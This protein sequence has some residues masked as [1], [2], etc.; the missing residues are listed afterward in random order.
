MC[1]ILFALEIDSQYPL[2]IAS[3]R[4]E[5]YER[6][7]QQAQFWEQNPHLL[8]GRDLKA[9]G[10]WLGVTRQRRLAMVTNF[11]GSVVASGERSRGALVQRFLV[12]EMM[13]EDYLTQIAQEADQYAGFNLVVAD[14]NEV[15]YY[16]NRSNQAPRRL[17]PGIYGLS[18]HL[19][20][21]PWPKVCQGKQ[22]LTQWLARSQKNPEDL[23]TLLA[24]P[25]TA[26]IDQ[27]PNTGIATEREQ[28]LSPI[29]IKT[30]GYGTRSS[31]LLLQNQDD[32]VCFKERSFNVSQ[33]DQTVEYL[34]PL[35]FQ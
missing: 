2:V 17:S 7:T 32:H 5:Y 21:T 3:N 28:S 20:D 1:L 35:Q 11:R 18:N 23:F 30:P 14:K 8:A 29:W 16:S 31:T 25:Q 27:L 24:D 15:W 22:K 12:G 9:G 6:P 19:L 13:P 10:S 33:D 34:F 4:D 26:P